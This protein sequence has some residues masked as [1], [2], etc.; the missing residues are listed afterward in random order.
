MLFS[1]AQ[2]FGKISYS[3]WG[4]HKSLPIFQYSYSQCCK[5]FLWGITT[6]IDSF[7]MPKH[8]NRW[9]FL[10]RI[11]L[12]KLYVA[13][14]DHFCWSTS[15]WEKSYFLHF[16]NKSIER[17]ANIFFQ[18]FVVMKSI[19]ISWHLILKYQIL[20]YQMRS[21]PKGSSH[22]KKWAPFFVL[23]FPRKILIGFWPQKKYFICV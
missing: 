4:W 17:W 21:I 20:E 7:L 13:K 11:T 15:Y 6:D 2:I 9:C 3:K 22:F 16:L 18:Y 19:K 1:P 5:G 12:Q 8:A 14:M 10:A 23:Q